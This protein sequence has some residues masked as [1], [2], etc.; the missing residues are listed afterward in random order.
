MR[1]FS[2][3]VCCLVL[4]IVIVGCKH[5]TIMPQL[6]YADEIID[7]N[8]D[9]A[10]DILCKI[11]QPA[12][13]NKPNRALYLLLLTQSKW[14]TDRDI[15]NDLQIEEAINYF[16]DVADNDHLAKAYLCKGIIYAQKSDA[17]NALD[18]YLKAETA[19][20]KTSDEHYKQ[21]IN[22]YIERLYGIQGNYVQLRR[23]D[24]KHHSAEV[25]V[26]K[27]VMTAA[28]IALLVLLTTAYIRQKRHKKLCDRYDKTIDSQEEYAK[29]LR[30]EILKKEEELAQ[31]NTYI[32]QSV[33]GNMA[34]ALAAIAHLRATNDI[35]ALSK[36][37]WSDIENIVNLFDNDFVKRAHDQNLSVRDKQICYLSLLFFK[38]KELS[39]IFHLAPNT[40]SKIKLKYLNSK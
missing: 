1:K 38:P 34:P 21:L 13:L 26:I 9:S 16:E 22:L 12:S 25:V 14:K 24:K 15:T 28:I 17:F 6:L 11:S 30:A 2:L 18:N 39:E 20:E 5:E 19:I 7:E 40:I 32:K 10:Y 27:F 31:K 8:P 35:S 4:A 3:Y 23:M 37:Q 33:S 36:K 29:T